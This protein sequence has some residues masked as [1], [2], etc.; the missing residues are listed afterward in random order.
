MMMREI[1]RR[2]ELMTNYL[3]Q[4]DCQT[5]EDETK[6]DESNLE[7]IMLQNKALSISKDMTAR[8]QETSLGRETK[9]GSQLMCELYTEL[10]CGNSG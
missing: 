5:A 8:C 6:L 10:C 1:V 2:L 9:K 3:L 7:Y 4:D